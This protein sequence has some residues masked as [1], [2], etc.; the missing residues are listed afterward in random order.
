MLQVWFLEANTNPAV[1]YQNAWHEALVDGMVG[2]G[3]ACCR[4]RTRLH[5]CALP[6]VARPVTPVV[7]QIEDIFRVAIDPIFPAPAPAGD[8]TAS[9]SA[10]AAAAPSASDSSAPGEGHGVDARPRFKL[11]YSFGQPRERLSPAD[12]EATAAPD[13]TTPVDAGA[14][15]AA[16]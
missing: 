13:A 12:A 7:W 10:S 11:L 8:T 3:V 4:C 6:D 14:R 1:M 9:A 5:D 16:V 15:A 2:S